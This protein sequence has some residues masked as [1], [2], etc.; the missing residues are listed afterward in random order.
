V[1]CGLQGIE[2][3][4]FSLVLNFLQMLATFQVSRPS[5]SALVIW[6]LCLN[7]LCFVDRQNYKLKW[8]SGGSTLFSTASFANFNVELLSMS[9]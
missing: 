5:C 9:V 3:A 1:S 6:S 7:M 2:L 8:P 4:V